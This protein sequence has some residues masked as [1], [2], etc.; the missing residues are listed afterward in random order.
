[1]RDGVGCGPAAPSKKDGSGRSE[2]GGS[3][4][5]GWLRSIAVNG[6]P[7]ERLLLRG[8]CSLSDEELVAVLLGTGV[9]GQSVHQLAADVLTR[10]GG[11]Q[12]LRTADAKAVALKGV[13]PAKAARLLASLELAV[14]LAASE[15]PRRARMDCPESAARYLYLRYA[16]F[17]QEVMGAA[18][19]NVRNEMI[20]ESEVFRGTLTRASVEPRTLLKEALLVGAAGVLV[21]HTHPS[22]DPSASNED[23]FFTRRLSA[24]CDAL[25]VRLVDH[26]ILGAP[27]RWTSMR[28]E[29][30]L[31][32]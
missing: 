20:H 16:R 28:R 1:M 10:L 6:A 19:L 18:F 7:R 4:A 30:V 23:V 3:V 21:F 24:A 12:G 27:Q 26:L 2:P 9:R 5:A 8:A 11:L 14:R 25:G 17:D 29:G 32:S 31:E 22:G 13:G 15:L